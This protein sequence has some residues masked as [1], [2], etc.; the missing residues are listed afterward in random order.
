MCKNHTNCSLL[1]G[2]NCTQLSPYKIRHIKIPQSS[3]MSDKNTKNYTQDVKIHIF[4]EICYHSVQN[5]HLPRFYVNIL[6]SRYIKTHLS[7]KYI[8]LPHSVYVYIQYLRTGKDSH[9]WYLK[10]A[11]TL[12]GSKRKA[13]WKKIYN[14]ELHYYSPHLFA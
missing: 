5:L 11:W 13:R 7:Y 14:Q 2:N 3:D 8:R 4:K 12:Y 1:P 6:R 10:T 9:R